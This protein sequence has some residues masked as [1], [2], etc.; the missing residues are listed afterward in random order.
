MSWS[1]QG[2]T[3]QFLF[4][5]QDLSVFV[6]NSMPCMHRHY[7][8]GQK[9]PHEY[10]NLA[11]DLCLVLLW[12]FQKLF[13]QFGHFPACICQCLQFKSF[14]WQGMLLMSCFQEIGGKLESLRAWFLKLKKKSLKPIQ[15]FYRLSNEKFADRYIKYTHRY[16]KYTHR[17]TKSMPK[18]SCSS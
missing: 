18:K 11:T 6:L 2:P 17:C 16:P 7:S 1:V 10:Q 13:T 14:P 3:C 9:Q 8:E 12:V 4:W 15:N 5:I